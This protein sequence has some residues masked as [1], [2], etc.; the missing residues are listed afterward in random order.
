M[1][2]NI[3]ELRTQA[4]FMRDK[5]IETR[6]A[7]ENEQVVIPYDNGGGQ[8]GIRANPAFKE[9]EN[10]LNSF[11]RTL[12]AIRELGGEEPDDD[13][14]AEILRQF[15]EADTNKKNNTA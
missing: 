5:L 4:D 15:G 14:I 11:T 3:D 10:L 12:T 8:T 9:Y 6:K 1:S 2:K 13:D 7:L